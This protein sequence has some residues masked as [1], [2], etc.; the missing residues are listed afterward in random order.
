MLDRY[1]KV[2]LTII[3]TALVGLFI[4][5]LV[6]PVFAEDPKVVKAVICDPYNLSR[7][8]RVFQDGDQYEWSSKNFLHTR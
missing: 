6:R 5:N 8:A 3:A 7:C 2:V 4:Q 1:S